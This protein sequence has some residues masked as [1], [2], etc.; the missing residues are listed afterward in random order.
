M[1][2]T[3]RAWMGAGAV[4]ALFIAAFFGLPQGSVEQSAAY[5][6][7]GLAMVA[8]G[9]LG[10]R[11]HRPS[12]WLPWL[13]LVAGQL[14]FVIGDII[15]TVYQAN[16]EDPFPSIADASYIVGYPILAL[17][18]AIAIRRRVSGGDRAGLLDGA[19]LACGAVVVWWSFVVGP[20]VAASDPDPLSFAIG[21]AYP[22]GDLLLIGLAL[23]LVMTP[24]AKSPSFALL[25]ANLS[26]VL[27][28]DLAFN[29]QTLDGTYVDG[30]VLDGV[31]L[32]AYTAFAMAALHPSMAEVFDPRP[33]PIALLG[34][35]RYVLLGAAMLV[36][37]ALLVIQQENAGTLTWVVACATAVLSVLVLTRLAG[38]VGHL[39]KDIQRR[40][41]LEEQ[42]S[43][44]ALHDPLTNLTNRRGFMKAVASAIG[45]GAST[46]VL[47]L[48]LDDFK[49]VN[50]NMGHDAGDALLS[51]VGHRI[52]AAIRPDDVGC[53]I[54]GDEFAILL[55]DTNLADA[56]SVG[57]R[58]L[59]SL[60][61][62]V[63]I[64]GS[65][66]VVPASIG[67]A[68]SAPFEKPT[69]DELLRRA[70][71]AMYNAK[72]A[73]KHRLAVYSPEVSAVASPVARSV[74]HTR[75]PR[76]TPAT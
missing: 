71:T 22:I 42:L 16:G 9:L 1:D 68:V 47:F 44:Q 45:T 28:G 27:L 7:C 62:P 53:R 57:R 61:T 74:R 36:G 19:I 72:A 40:A 20:L 33:L 50:D 58:L 3:Q 73:G 5:D 14:A 23:G 46:G 11:M 4:G 59:S 31:W 21:V 51:A 49:H 37:P 70:D 10:V 34:P 55:P 63:P 56:E 24:G 25:V 13:I 29:L 67:V 41:I 26:I 38:V 8:F 60:S 66:L 18:L 48:D 43:F 39:D 64:E 54:G 65:R 17:G 12:G 69:V 52:V 15:W 75:V 32:V 30:G 76:V 2:L 6:A 35:V